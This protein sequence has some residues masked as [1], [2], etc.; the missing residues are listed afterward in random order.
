MKKILLDLK[1]ELWATSEDAMLINRYLD[2]IIELES[3][4]QDIS[5]QLDSGDMKYLYWCLIDVICHWN[6][7]S[8]HEIREEKKQIIKIN[9]KI[10]R[11]AK[12]LADLLRE[13]EELS[14]VGHF[15]AYEDYSVK[16]WLDR[17]GSDVILYPST[18]GA[19][20]TKLKSRYG[21]KYW[22]KPDSVIDA[23]AIFAEETEVLAKDPYTEKLTSTRKVSIQ[24]TVQVILEV[25]SQCKDPC[26]SSRKLFPKG[27]KLKD[28]SIADLVNVTLGLQDDE[29]IDGP[30]VKKMR[31]NLRNA[32]LIESQNT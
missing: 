26:M 20:L 31:Q 11:A 19:E 7:D 28:N 1:K 13:R 12:E 9:K 22:P 30:S 24:N 6:T 25:I 15:Y 18:V 27:F 4:H 5:S 3:V 32:G 16:H 10:E 14:E 17:A 23:I 29:M 8:L 21:N 2:R